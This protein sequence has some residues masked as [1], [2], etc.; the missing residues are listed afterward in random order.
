MADATA[1]GVVVVDADTRKAQKAFQDLSKQVGSAKASLDLARGSGGNFAGTLTKLSGAMGGFSGGPGQGFL[2]LLGSATGL[3][4]KIVPIV[5][6]IIVAMEAFKIVTQTVIPWLSKLLETQL[7][8]NESW[9]AGTKDLGDLRTER[10]RQSSLDL[11]ER[12]DAFL[13][14]D[15]AKD[16]EFAAQYAAAKADVAKKKRRGGGGGGGGLDRRP[17]SPGGILSQ[18]RTPEEYAADEEDRRI[19]E[20]MA[21]AE[22]NRNIY[23]QSGGAAGLREMARSTANAGKA[24][25]LENA[26]AEV[27]ENLAK[28]EDAFSVFSAGISSAIDAAISGE[29]S[30]GKAALRGASAALRSIAVQAPVKAL[31]EVAQGWAKLGNPVTAPQ[32]AAHFA[33]AKVFALAGLAAGAGAAALGGGGGGG[34]GGG[35][36]AG[37]AGGGHIRGGGG[38]GEKTENISIV[39]NGWVGNKAELGAEI[40]KQLRAAKGTGKVRDDG[41]RSVK[42]LGG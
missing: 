24:A 2:T 14:R 29:E 23:A 20:G 5:G 8:L 19:R 40:H 15:L 7:K 17:D 9:V 12:V 41:E 18:G 4:S 1:R 11:V 33:S 37:T 35:A 13:A 39:I 25:E 16:A 10:A 31:W 6:T 28:Y 34:G 27:A 32:A 30:I 36:S 38:G 22:A 3:L 26:E 21:A 42:F